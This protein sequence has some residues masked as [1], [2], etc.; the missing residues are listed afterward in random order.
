MLNML[1]ILMV[2]YMWNNK[3]E[4]HNIQIVIKI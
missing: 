1:I 4:S 2:N 3:N